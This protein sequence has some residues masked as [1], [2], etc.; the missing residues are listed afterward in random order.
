[1]FRSYRGLTDGLI[2]QLEPHL[3]VELLNQGSFNPVRHIKSL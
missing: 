3:N 1:M 2:T